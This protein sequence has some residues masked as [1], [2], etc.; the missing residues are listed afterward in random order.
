MPMLL[1]APNSILHR[2]PIT[3][4]PFPFLN[5]VDLHLLQLR[6]Q[7]IALQVPISN[8]HLFVLWTD[9][10]DDVRGIH[11][12]LVDTRYGGP[13]ERGPGKEFF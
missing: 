8:G 11:H 2:L 7:K 4:R 6:M 9:E 12:V 3:T 10:F 1:P 5:F 13:A